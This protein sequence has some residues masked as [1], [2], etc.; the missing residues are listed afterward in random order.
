VSLIFPHAD[1]G[2]DFYLD[3]KFRSNP[4][5]VGDH[6]D[7]EHRLSRVV[8]QGLWT[9][10]FC[11]DENFGFVDYFFIALLLAFGQIST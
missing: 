6:D 1:A 11:F 5:Q 8:F 2:F 4:F 9:V 7:A 3:V 10:I